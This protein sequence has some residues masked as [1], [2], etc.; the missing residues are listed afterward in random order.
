MNLMSGEPG[1]AV[2]VISLAGTEGLTD[3][4]EEIAGSG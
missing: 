4:R 3:L 2:R 1:I